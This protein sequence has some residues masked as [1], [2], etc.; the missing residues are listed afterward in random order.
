MTFKSAVIV[1]VTVPIPRNDEQNGFVEWDS[2]LAMTER[3]LECCCG[4]GLRTSILPGEA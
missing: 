4:V 2:S 1:F 3:V